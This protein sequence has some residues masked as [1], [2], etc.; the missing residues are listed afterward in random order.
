MK[1]Y[2]VYMLTNINKTVLYVG[3]SNDIV[4]RIQEHKEKKFEGFTKFY[5]VDRLVYF[6][7]HDTI[8]DAIYRERQL[9]KWNRKWKENLINKQNPKWKDLSEDLNK[10]LT[11]LEILGILFGDGYDRE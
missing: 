7:K 2:F 9:K 1:T 10:K 4:R 3:F 8:E 6:D 5:N 11:D